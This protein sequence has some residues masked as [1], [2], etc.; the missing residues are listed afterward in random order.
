MHEV[1]PFPSPDPQG[2]GRG[3]SVPF[4]GC[5][6]LQPRA[7]QRWDPFLWSL[8]WHHCY[9]LGLTA[10]LLQLFGTIIFEK[11]GREDFKSSW[12]NTGKYPKSVTFSINVAVWGCRP[13]SERAVWC[14]SFCFSKR[15]YDKELVFWR[16][17]DPRVGV[18]AVQWLLTTPW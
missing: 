12:E 7:L 6:S 14:I 13:P 2:K 10:K 16:F 1:I 15:T 3:F 5:P 8:V 9:S 18:W 4:R 11:T 17:P